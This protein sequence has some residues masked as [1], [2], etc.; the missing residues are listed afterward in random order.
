MNRKFQEL[1]AILLGLTVF[2]IMFVLMTCSLHPVCCV[3]RI[4]DILMFMDFKEKTKCNNN[5]T[6]DD[7]TPSGVHIPIF[8]VYIIC[9]MSCV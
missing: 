5:Y 8:M 9:R 1:R 2:Y 3:W 7:T 6:A 4:N